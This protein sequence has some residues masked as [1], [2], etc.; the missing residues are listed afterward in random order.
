MSEKFTGNVKTS[1]LLIVN[2]MSDKFT[3]N[4]KTSCLLI[5]NW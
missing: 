3:G 2:W 4:D 5:V 1:C